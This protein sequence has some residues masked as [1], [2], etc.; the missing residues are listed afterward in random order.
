M[1]TEK[2]QLK[3]GIGLILVSALMTCSGQLFWKLGADNEQ[4][5]IAFYLLGFVLYGIGALLM[6]VAFKFG[7]MSVLHPMLSV[8]FICS[9]ILGNK[10]LGEDISYRKIM[11]II[12]ILV[13]VCLL[14]YQ[15]DKEENKGK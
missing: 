4:Y 1:K 10:F 5:M 9:L 8:G 13:G 7:E 15:G 6:L 3:M 12:F 2:N 11:G 14:S